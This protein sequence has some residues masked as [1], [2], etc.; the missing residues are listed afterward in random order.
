MDCAVKK[1]IG[2]MAYISDLVTMLSFNFIVGLNVTFF[3]SKPII[4]HSH[5]P[6]Q[7]KVKFKPRMNHNI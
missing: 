2:I 3:C 7:R 4:I 5:T 6:K 1:N